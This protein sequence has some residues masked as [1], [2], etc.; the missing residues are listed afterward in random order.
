MGS[1]KV[2][3]AVLSHGKR[4]DTLVSRP[5]RLTPS[6]HGGVVYAGDVY[7]LRA[8]NSI[9]V[10][11]ASYDKTSCS[12]FVDAGEP[13]P[14][15]PSSTPAQPP[16]V[17][18]KRWYVE[19]NRFG[20]YL[21][22]DASVTLAERVVALMDSSGIG[23][24]RWD[25]SVRVS[26]NGE[27]YDWFI[28]LAFDGSREECLRRVRHVL[29]ATGPATSA[30]S[31]ILSSTQADSVRE[32]AELLDQMQ[33]DLRVLRSELQALKTYQETER[34]R[35]IDQ[36]TAAKRLA[37]KQVDGLTRD[38]HEARSGRRALE[39]QVSELEALLEEVTDPSATT[40]SADEAV[41]SARAAERH[42]IDQ[43]K[44]AALEVDD[45]QTDVR[46]L[47]A[48]LDSARD[49]AEFYESNYRTAVEER[50]EHREKRRSV[51]SA[52]GGGGPRGSTELFLER[53][54]ERLDLSA[55]GIDLLL[56]WP[57]P[58]AAVKHLL[59]IEDRTDERLRTK[60]VGRDGWWELRTHTGHAAH[61]D[62]GRIYYHPTKD[63]RVDVELHHKK[64]KKDQNRFLR[65][66]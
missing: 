43:W 24:R 56:E 34:D 62:M 18:L 66:M 11:G 21:V 49:A 12:S 2:D 42:A 7:P 55:D 8:D 54:F 26:D 25:E 28:R 37:Q 3:V 39:T 64:D 50:D 15:G 63:G 14:Y 52:H 4:I 16:G 31:A 19:S 5:V 30:P 35:L 46:T 47:R 61:G 48:E 1:A 58:A 33:D 23:V 20:H 17:Q 9:E 57:R 40:P 60:V 22:F 27:Q 38:L 65:A 41:S 13:V 32:A 6:G 44:A 51:A 10:T 29:A 36:F 59:S 53:L 45:L